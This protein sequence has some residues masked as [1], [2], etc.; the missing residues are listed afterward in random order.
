M[1]E[2]IEKYFVACDGKRFND[3]DKCREYEESLINEKELKQQILKLNKELAKV[4]YSLYR[5]EHYPQSSKSAGGCGNSGYYSKCPNCEELIGGYERTNTTL[6]V[7]KNTYK[8][9]K[10]GTFF[11]Y[12]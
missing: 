3:E 6:E 12:K 2:V 10:C 4:E 7:D 8:C 5:I 9:E 1:R 11:T